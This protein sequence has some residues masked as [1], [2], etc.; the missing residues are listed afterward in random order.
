MGTTLWAL[1]LTTAPV[2]PASA[3]TLHST[4]TDTPDHYPPALPKRDE[5]FPP[6][7]T[8]RPVSEIPLPGP[9]PGG[10]LRLEDG[11]I[12][13]PV[14][15]GVA[16]VS[17]GADLTVAVEPAEALPLPNPSDGDQDGWVF[18]PDLRRRYRSLPEGRIL[19]E[20][21]RRRGWRRAWSLRV[22]GAILAP[23]LLVG[24]RLFFGSLS[25]Q[26]YAT[27]S[28][29]GHRLWAVDVGDRVSRPLTLWQ[30]EIP[31]LDPHS[32]HP[33]PCKLSLVLLVPDG[34][35][36]L[37]ALDPY[38]G[39]RI[40]SFELPSAHERLIPPAMA[41]PDGRVLVATQKY[42]ASAASLMVLR[43]SPPEPAAAPGSGVAYNEADPPEGADTE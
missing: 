23:P 5:P 34:G 16:I 39:S 28:D 21:Q 7:L 9:L 43:L 25:N 4:T 27:R 35:A 38:D 41:T 13:L 3:Q 17:L 11:L 33:T 26:V 1:T 32:P 22:A 18:S 36:S 42:A 14:A 19:A 2:V 10:P 40:A 24:R 29:N 6:A 30:G 12:T 8:F 37:I 15:G 31:S 20:R